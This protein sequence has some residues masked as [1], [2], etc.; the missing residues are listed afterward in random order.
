V[1]V[2]TIA[3]GLRIEGLVEAE[4]DLLIEGTVEGR[5]AAGGKIT[6]AAGA[7]C[8]SSVRAPSLLIVGELIGNAVCTSAIDVAAGARV[9]GDLRAPDIQVGA[10]AEVDGRVDVLLPEPDARTVERTAMETRSIGSMRPQ[11]PTAN[12][13]IPSPPTP[14]GRI[15][16]TPRGRQS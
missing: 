9:V 2:S 8:R 12:R 14:S 1:S 4:G 16:V 6:I 5:I 15:R 7:S 13:E 10:N 11:R 3:P